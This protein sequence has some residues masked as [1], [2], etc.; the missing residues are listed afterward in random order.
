MTSVLPLMLATMVALVASG[1]LRAD[2]GLA[3]LAINDEALAIPDM[4]V[5]TSEGRQAG[6]REMLPPR[7]PVILSFT[8]TGCASICD[9]T[10]AILLGVEDELRLDDAEAV[11][12]AT[13]SIDPWNDTPEALAHEKA[14]LGAGWLWLTGGPT[15]TQPILDALR[16]PPGAISD[17]DPMFLVGRPCSG[18]MTRVVGLANPEDLVA[19]ARGLPRC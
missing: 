7:A 18:R 11:Q 10:N 17:H 8:F 5:T 2:S 14:K 19:L 9:I 3:G 13:L 1:P 15:G 6:L 4:T 16:F 12:I